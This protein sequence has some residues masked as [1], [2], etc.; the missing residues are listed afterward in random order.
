MGIFGIQLAPNVD[1]VF[2]DIDGNKAGDLLPQL[3]SMERGT[4]QNRLVCCVAE[5]PDLIS[6]EEGEKNIS[7]TAVRSSRF[8]GPVEKGGGGRWYRGV[9]F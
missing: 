5:V 1:P 2:C 4:L 9:P 7:A 6:D 3:E 8:V